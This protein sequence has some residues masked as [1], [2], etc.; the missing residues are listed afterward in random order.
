[1]LVVDLAMLK[2]ALEIY[3]KYIDF[4]AGNESPDLKLGFIGVFFK[5]L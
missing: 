1:M 4:G 5:T 3:F 2:G